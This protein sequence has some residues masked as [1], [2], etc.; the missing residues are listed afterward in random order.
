[1]G[2]LPHRSSRTGA[3]LT[4]ATAAEGR[5]IIAG[6]FPDPSICRF[7]ETY[8]VVH[9]SFEYAP[10]IPVWTSADLVTWEQI[11]NALDRSSQLRLQPMQYW[12]DGRRL[13][14]DVG[15][16]PVGSA[17][18]GN[19]A[20]TIRAHEGRLWL[21]VTNASDLAG[22]PLVFWADDP[23][24]PWSDPVQVH[25]LTMGIDPD[26]FWDSDGVAHVTV[27]SYVDGGP[28]I[29]SAP[30]DLA[31]GE[32]LGA[33]RRLWSGTGGQAPE[34]PHLYRKDSWIYLLI[35]EGG[36]ERGH[37]V[38]VARARSLEGPWETAPHNPILTHRGLDRPVQNAGHADLVEGPDGRWAMVY[39]GV[40]PSGFSGF[41]VNGRETFLAAVHWRDGWPVVDESGFEVPPPRHSFVDDFSTDSLHP[42]WIAPGRLPE[43]FTY[44]ANP[45]RWIEAASERPDPHHFLATRPRDPHWIAHLD[46]TPGEGEAGLCVRVDERHSAEALVAGGRFRSRIQVGDLER[47][48]HGPRITSDSAQL[49]IEAQPTHAPPLLRGPDVVEIGYLTDGVRVPLD[50]IDGRYLSVEVAGGWTGRVIG[51][52]AIL[53]RIRLNTFCYEARTS[54]ERP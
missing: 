30:V 4:G 29:V 54:E 6:F 42:R 27:S 15:G 5:P 36:T 33:P 37:A 43:S 17:N 34:A 44:P 52:R 13:S 50:R 19:W 10:G 3:E 51:V 46:I 23:A 38:T 39:L 28:H 16:V 53:G 41:H 40:R 47:R 22:G 49:Y 14:A 35:A 2:V 8:V 48:T 24:G 45:G 11:G 26:L 18:T 20:P 7:G 32:L 12:L 1:M 9:S 31:T 25:G 21:T